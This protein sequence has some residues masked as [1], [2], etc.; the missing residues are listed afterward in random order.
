MTSEGEDTSARYPWRAL[1]HHS[2]TRKW[3]TVDSATAAWRQQLQKAAR[4]DFEEGGDE[5]RRNRGRRGG[6]AIAVI[7]S[8]LFRADG[9]RAPPIVR[10]RPLCRQPPKWWN[11]QQQPTPNIGVFTITFYIS[12]SSGTVVRPSSAY[13]SGM[14][15]NTP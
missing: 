11:L 2:A 5:Q 6:I 8:P 1:K 3:A 13:C 4:H 10:H 12:M 15:V 7:A 14:A 9:V